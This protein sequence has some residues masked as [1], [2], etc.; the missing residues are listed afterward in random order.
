MNILI[1]NGSPA[2]DDSITL[3]TVRY[4]QK[5][6]PGHE[7]RQLNVVKRLKALEKDFSEASALLKE[8]ELLL[9]SYPVY[10]FLAPAQLHSFISL[11]KASGTDLRGKYATQ[12]TTS[13]HFY[14]VTAHEYIREN[15]ADLGLRYIRGL[16]ADMEDLLSEKGQAEAG[17]FFARVLWA[18]GQGFDE[19]LP[20]SAEAPFVPVPA[21][22][23]PAEAGMHSTKQVVVVADM[24]PAD[25]VLPAMVERFCRVCPS[26]VRVV[27]IREFAF[28]GGCLGCF[29]CAADGTCF[30]KDGFDK[31]LREEIQGADA[32]V[33]AF[34]I[35]DH[36]MGCRFK[37]YDDRQFCNGHRTVTMGK[38]VGYLVDGPLSAEANLRMLLEARA[39]V[40]GNHL[41]RI[42]GNERDTDAEIDRLAAALDYDLRADFR[43]PANFYGVGGMKI[44]R[45]LIFT[46]QGLMRED[47]RFYRKHG[48]YRDFPQRHRGKIAAM[49]L[50]GAMMNSPKLA[51]KLG[52]NMT[53]GMLMPYENVLK[54]VRPEE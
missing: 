6:F 47:H 51:K 41:S 5:R 17:A 22:L 19:A 15:C 35:R 54:K 3:Q 21:T 26:P 28:A 18:I 13:K 1:I 44:F 16:S 31:L 38:P 14:D 27:N 42:A 33:Y 50:V 45:D 2:G 46:M 10:T 30:Y 9:F 36:S 34:T 48:F 24:D 53:K 20:R 12:L 37:Y 4:L 7:W 52:G 32:T 39:Q 49:Y 43:E 25:T 11:M 23:P 29:R 8:A 40:G